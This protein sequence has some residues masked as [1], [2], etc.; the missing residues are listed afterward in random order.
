MAAWVRASMI[1]PRSL[2]SDAGNSFCN[3]FKYLMA[4]EYS[5]TLYRAAPSSR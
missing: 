3:W 1:F 4:S 5:F 2:T